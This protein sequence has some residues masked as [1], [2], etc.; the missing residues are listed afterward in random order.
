MEVD[1]EEEEDDQDEDFEGEE[2]EEESDEE[3]YAS[4]PVMQ[5]TGISLNNIPTPPLTLHP[6]PSPPFLS[7]GREQLSDEEMEGEGDDEMGEGE[8]WE[9]EEEEEEGEEDWRDSEVRTWV[10]PMILFTVRVMEGAG[11]HRK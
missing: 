11:E 10:R 9:G 1:G 4:A 3:E 7:Q 2:G 6:L 5:W 8:E